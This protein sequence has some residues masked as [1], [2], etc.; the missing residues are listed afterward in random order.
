MASLRKVP[1][2]SGEI[3]H[4]YNR[5]VDKR[6]TFL[7]VG[8]YLRF[9][10]LAKFYQHSD[11]PVRFSYFIRFTP[12]TV[13]KLMN[14]NWGENLVSILGYC[15]MPNHFHFILR[16]EADGGISRFISNLINSYT[17]YFN[18]KNDR[19]GP[20]FLEDFQNVLV[21]NEQQFLHLTRYIHLN[22]YSA[23]LVV[24]L[25]DLENYEWSSYKEYLGRS[26]DY[27]CDRVIV[28]A[29]FKNKENYK[30]FVN[31]RSDYQRNLK[32]MEYLWEDEK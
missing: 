17:R 19:V 16:Q 30:S 1:L 4:I 8:E 5:G 21:S 6:K 13:E 2:V 7:D 26:D 14:E 12:K 29:S 25:K 22:P 10:Q 27:V 24:N 3:Y 15:F 23:S 9:Y 20:L 31:D 18:I 28:E 11:P 32:N